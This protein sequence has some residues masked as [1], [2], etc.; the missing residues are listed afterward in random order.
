MKIIKLSEIFSEYNIYQLKSYSE[1]TPVRVFQKLFPNHYYSKD[2]KEFLSLHNYKSLKRGA[3]LPW[4]GS[5][6]FQ[7]NDKNKVMIISQDS[8]SKDAGSIAFWAHLYDVI[9]NKDEYEKYTSVLESKKLF[10]YNSWQKIY[11]QFLHWNIN[12]DCCYIT[13]AS[14][15]YKDGSYK[16][17]DLDIKKSRELLY[18][19]IEICKPNLIILLGTPPLKLLLP[20]VKYKDAV[21]D[22]V[23][24]DF[25]DSKV[26]V[27]PFISGQG[28]TQKN[29][30][31]RLEIA[32]NL[33]KSYVK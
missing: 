23:Y 19:E 7:C 9:N 14:K 10:T 21:E 30:K 15:V 5:G 17:G 33:I 3:D 27:A 2:I 1:N 11:N 31:E 8:L 29:Y 26:V 6:F 24:L 13:D 22:G 12:L 18:K 16:D 4:W 20:N 28:C 25:N 32:T